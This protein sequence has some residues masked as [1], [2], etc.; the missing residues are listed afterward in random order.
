MAILELEK[1]EVESPCVHCHLQNAHLKAPLSVTASEVS[2]FYMPLSTGHLS[3]M[4][5]AILQGLPS[6]SEHVCSWLQVPACLFLHGSRVWTLRS[7]ACH[8]LYPRVR[9]ISVGAM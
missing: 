6:V 8:S 1:T 2:L 9:A 5:S 4:Q 7:R 3:I